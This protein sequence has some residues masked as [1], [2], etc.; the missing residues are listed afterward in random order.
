MKFKQTV[1]QVQKT[2]GEI[3]NK[4]IGIYAANASFFILLSIFPALM[5][6]LSLLQYTPL[7][8]KDLLDAINS[9]VPSLMEPLINYI[10]TDL[11]ASN[12]IALISISAITAIWSSSRGVYSLWTGLNGVYGLKDRRN[13]L[14]QRILC[15][16]Y[17]LLLFVALLITMI[18]HVFGKSISRFLASKPIPL[19]RLLLFF[20]DMRW[21]VVTLILT[22]L[23]TVIFL[24][25]PN[26]KLKIRQVLPGAVGSAL[27]WVVF[28]SLFSFYVDKFSNYSRLYGSL[29]II[30]VSMLWLYIC[31]CILFY[32]AV[33]NT[34]IERWKK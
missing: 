16:F 23:F 10:V 9:L 28:S 34:Y 20:M 15:M 31:I 30:A 33:F 3:A 11:F 6:I 8:Q 5:L 7:T 13:Y 18:L 2:A 27:G 24:V 14:F 26:R 22:A 1:Q 17:T 12:S 4:K 25:F 19:F 21:L 29:S 32:G